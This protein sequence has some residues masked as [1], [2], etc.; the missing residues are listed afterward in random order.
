MHLFRFVG[1]KLLLYFI[2]GLFAF[3]VHVQLNVLLRSLQCLNVSSLD[4]NSFSAMCFVFMTS[5]IAQGGG[6]I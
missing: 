4:L 1:A 2:V 6:R 5:A 3:F